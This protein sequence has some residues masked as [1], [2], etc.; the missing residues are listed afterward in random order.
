MCQGQ[1][2]HNILQDQAQ[3]LGISIIYQELNL[4]SNLSIAE[5]IFLGR[6]KR[7]A[8]VF[9]DRDATLKDSRSLMESVGLA[10]DP[11]TLVEDLSISHRQMVAV[12]KALSLNAELYIMDEPTSTLTENE[13]SVLFALIRKMRAQ[14]KSVIFVSH[15]SVGFRRMPI[16]ESS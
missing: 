2:K 1:C 15:K 11:R 13:V 4:V 6:E 10:M 8:S 7:K 3:E 5:N 12:A 14:N 16:S 9:F